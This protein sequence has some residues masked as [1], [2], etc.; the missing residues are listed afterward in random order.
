M[1]TKKIKDQPNHSEACA[2][3]K[4]GSSSSKGSK[5]ARKNVAPSLEKQKST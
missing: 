2:M 4:P 1:G 5:A 3:D